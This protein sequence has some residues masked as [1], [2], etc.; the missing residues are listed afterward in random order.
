MKSPIVPAILEESF[1]T[2]SDMVSR[3]SGATDTVQ[4]DIVDGMYAQ[5]MT[6]P[7]TVLDDVSAIS[8][9]NKDLIKEVQRLYTLK[10]VFEV[11]LMVQNP[12]DTLGLWLMTDA[13]RFIIHRMSTK[14]LTY[15]INRIKSDDQEVYV[16]LTSN[17]TPESIKP[18]IEF[19]D[20][21]QCMGI[22]QIGKQG[23]PYDE[24]IEKLVTAL[25]DTYPD[26]PIQIDGG[27]SAQTIPR[28]LEAGAKKFAVGS[29]IFSGDAEKNL[30]DLSKLYADTK[31]IV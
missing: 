18:V 22:D 11:D 25:R 2:I 15:C 21:V 7:F 3:V 23:E 29:A 26:L 30:A 20:G 1:D 9:T 31:V 8:D 17:D 14:Y 6:W 24:R 16:G 19:I 4:I 12:E 27:V 5:N 10:T 13:T 28:L